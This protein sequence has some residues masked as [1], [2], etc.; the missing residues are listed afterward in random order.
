MKDVMSKRRGAPSVD[1]GM[2]AEVIR[3]LRE[4]AGLVGKL[5]TR[6]AVA[7]WEKGFLTHQKVYREI[8][9]GFQLPF[10][11]EVRSQASD[12][13]LRHAVYERVWEL[14]ADKRQ[15][16]TVIL[17]TGDGGYRDLVR[18]LIG[19]GRRVIV[20]SWNG[21]GK[22]EDLAREATEFE[23]IEDVIGFDTLVRSR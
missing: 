8:D 5:A 13:E 22:S 23:S 18:K 7:A 12:D 2:L 6:F 16:S 11:S 10:P 17:V 3:R 4:R 9:S 20:W 1:D 14:V 19:D 21:S 15:I